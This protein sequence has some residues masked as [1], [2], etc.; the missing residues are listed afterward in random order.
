MKT[1]S[2]ALQTHLA[3][4]LTK[5]ATCWRVTRT[6]LNVYGFTD[7]DKD[8]VFD[9]VLY[10]SSTGYFATDVSTASDLDV[11][12]LEVEGILSS[13]SITEDDLRA[14]R[15]DN[16]EIKIFQVNWSDLTMG[17]VNMRIG[18]IGNVSV[19]R[20]TFR[21]ELLGLTQAYTKTLGELTSAACRATL[22]D[23]R[24]KVNLTSGG[25]PELFTQTGTVG[26]FNDST[27]VITDASRTEA[28]NF[29]AHGKITFTSGENSG[30]SIEVKSSAVGSITLQLPPPYAVTTGTTY[31]AVAGC[32]KSLRTCIDRF[33][34]VVNFRGEPYLQGNDKLVQVGRHN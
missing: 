30:I 6:D 31:T 12:N 17:S 26:T 22:G 4:E 3:G 29:F 23:T 32:D 7:H 25:S 5:L 2:I 34:N 20:S 16:A 27:L 1:I 33:N 28:A 11:D 19:G 8:I 24:C 13:P 14:G 10:R 9:G 15:W 18:H 21:A